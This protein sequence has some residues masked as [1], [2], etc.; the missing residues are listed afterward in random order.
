MERHSYPV[1]PPAV[2][3]FSLP[4]APPFLHPSLSPFAF[5]SLYLL[6]CSPMV[7]MHVPSVV[8]SPCLCEVLQKQLYHAHKLIENEVII[9]RGHCKDILYKSASR[10]GCVCLLEAEKCKCRTSAESLFTFNL[11]F[12]NQNN[13]Q[14]V[15]HFIH[16]ARLNI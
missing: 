3:L 4:F 7:L 11:S 15:L 2:P 5:H 16:K 12:L 14:Y 8:T 1:L 10:N 6:L 9:E 13:N